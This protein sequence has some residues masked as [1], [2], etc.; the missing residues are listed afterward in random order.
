MMTPPAPGLDTVTVASAAIDVAPAALVAAIATLQDAAAASYERVVV[1]IEAAGAPAGTATLR[2]ALPSSQ[3]ARAP[4]LP[5]RG[6]RRPLGRCNRRWCPRRHCRGH[7]C[8][9]SPSGRPSLPHSWCRCPQWTCCGRHWALGHC[10][11]RWCPHRHC[12]GCR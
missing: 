10:R 1:A 6:R 11:H 4:P 8:C 7:H 2:S 9:W 3:P 12:R 5:C